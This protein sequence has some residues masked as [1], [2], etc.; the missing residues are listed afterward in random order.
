MLAVALDDRDEVVVATD[1]ALYHVAGGSWARIGWE[2]VG[3]VTWDGLRRVL[4]LTG[5]T[6]AAPAAAVLRLVRDWDLPEVA[7]ERVAWTRVLDQRLTLNGSGGARVLARR[8]PEKPELRWLVIV[9]NGLDPRDPG[10]RAALES[11]LRDLRAV[12]GV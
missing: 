5:L 4:A 10:L 1:W 9:D 11:A 7:S 8:V 12:T 6:P 2:N 3:Q